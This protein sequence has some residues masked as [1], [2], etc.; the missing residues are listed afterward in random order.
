ML[1]EGGREEECDLKD[2]N[3]GL[4]TMTS[5]NC[6]RGGTLKKLLTSLL[7]NMVNTFT[8]DTRELREASGRL[9]SR[10]RK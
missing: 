5:G 6:R 8:A 10:D 4:S 9:Q 3:L 7:H 2:H 1:K